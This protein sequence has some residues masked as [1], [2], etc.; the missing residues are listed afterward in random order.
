MKDICSLM[1]DLAYFAYL[2]QKREISDL[3]LKL[4][5]EVDKLAYFLYMTASLAARDKD[6]AEFSAVLIKVGTAFNELA[7]A[8]ADI[9]D[10]VKLS[11]SPHRSIQ[12]AFEKTEETVDDVNV[13]A[14]SLIDGKR[15]RDLEKFGIYIDI[16]A[17]KR[18]NSWLLNPDRNFII[19]GGDIL[20]VRGNIEMLTKMREVCKH[21]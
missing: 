15:V 19:R 10:M 8:A 4:E 18:N 14:N 21:E 9:A 7:N 13:E 20:I 12:E 17:L 11:L 3:V 2:K 5:S 16:I 1:V 6:D